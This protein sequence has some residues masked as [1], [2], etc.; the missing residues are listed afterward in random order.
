MLLQSLVLSFQ[1]EVSVHQ[2]LV[3]VVDSLQISVF[4]S[5]INF[6]TVELGLKALES[7]SELV[8]FVVFMTLR[9]QFHLL[10]VDQSGIYLFELANLHVETVDHALQF[11]N[12]TLSSVDLA[13]DIVGVFSSLVKL[14]SHALASMDQSLSFLVEN[15]DSSVL[16][17]ALLLPLRQGSVVLVDSALLSL[18]EFL[19]FRN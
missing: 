14:L 18:S 8:S 12:V 13:L 4:A 5:L 6:K 3:R 16:R 7:G 2:S 9:L 19:V 1:V 10:V 17:E 11:G 15:G